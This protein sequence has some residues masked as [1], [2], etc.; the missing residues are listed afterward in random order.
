MTISRQVLILMC[1]YVT[2]FYSAFL[3]HKAW[4]NSVAKPLW[5]NLQLN[6]L[7]YLSAEIGQAPVVTLSYY[8]C[9]AYFI[10]YI[11]PGSSN[12]IVG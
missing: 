4:S 2:Y 1:F 11:H 5:D 9:Q 6:V 3:E 12:A 10:L 7:N 8:C